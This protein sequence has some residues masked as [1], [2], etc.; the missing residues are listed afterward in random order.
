MTIDTGPAIRTPASRA[1]ALPVAL[2]AGLLLG[3]LDFLWI[4]FVPGPFGGLGNSVAVWAVAAFLL[5]FRH[6][7]TLR[8][9]LLAAGVQLIVAVPA[10][11]LAAALIQHDDPAN[12]YDT[13]ALAWAGLGVVAAL[14]FGT[15]G[16]LARGARTPDTVRH[17]ALALPGAVLFAEAGLQLRRIGEPSYSTGALTA[18]AAILLFLGL[19][20]TVLM[21]PAWRRRG[22][23]LALALP[24]TAAGFVAFDLTGLH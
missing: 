21:V 13:T 6:R 11:H 24:L 14:V 3:V 12:A 15:G 17:L 10:Y 20:T 9:S 19:L 22:L 23:V 8:V 1:A 5:T 18:Y 7:W 4:K 2:V 16:A